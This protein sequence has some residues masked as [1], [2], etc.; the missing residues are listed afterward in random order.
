M[1]ATCQIRTEPSYRHDAFLAGL[2]RAGYEIK[3][4]WPADNRDLLVVWNRHGHVDSEAAEWERRGGT[5][6][7]AENGYLGKDAEGRQ[8]FAM[9]IHGHNGSGWFPIG[10]GDRFARL[11]VQLH[12]WREVAADA[13]LLLCAQRGIGSKT[14]ASPARWIENSTKKLAELGCTNLRI[15]RHPG[16]VPPKTTL[17]EDLEGVRA[18]VIWSSAAGITALTQGIPVVYTAPHWICA[19]AAVR[20]LPSINELVRDDARRLRALQK[21]A[22]GQHTVAEIESGAPF[23]AFRERLGEAKW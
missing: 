4:G 9:S 5:V 15:R 14:M 3:S 18:A 12:P 19:D 2:K 16:Q 11:G 20:G 17:L 21:M 23:V 8:L 1:K 22:W 10:D 6:I 7:V 13:P